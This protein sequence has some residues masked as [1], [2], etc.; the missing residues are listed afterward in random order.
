MLFIM[1]IHVHIYAITL[2]ISKFMNT[3]KILLL[4]LQ[5][6]ITFTQAIFIPGQ[7]EGSRET[8]NVGEGYQ[9][10]GP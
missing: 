1:Y 3:I 6:A 8:P 7:S 4:S 2:S 5:S 10:S 9:P